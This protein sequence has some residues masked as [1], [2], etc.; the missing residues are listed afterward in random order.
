MIRAAYVM[1]AQEPWGMTPSEIDELTDWQ[2]ENL[3]AKP[4]AE[5]AEEI[6]KDMPERSS[7]P[8]R[9]GAKSEQP[10]PE[11]GTPAHRFLMMSA[12]L[13][14][15]FPMSPEKAEREYERQMAQWRA[16]QQGA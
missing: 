11:P 7:E 15:P 1:L 12:F 16:S 10:M 5:R 4:A 13:N 3:Y 9:P 2:I 8:S 14:G 6:R